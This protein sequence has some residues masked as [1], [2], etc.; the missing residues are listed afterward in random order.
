MKTAKLG[1]YSVDPPALDAFHA[2]DPESFVTLLAISDALVAISPEGDVIPSLA[3]G[4]E[5][6]SP[7]TLELELREGVRF[8]NGEAFDADSVVATF[9]AHH[10]PTPSACGGG[11]LAS[12]SDVKRLG[13]HRV[14][15]TTAFPDAM[16]LRRLF[17]FSIYPKGVLESEGRGAMLRHPIGTG[18]WRFVHWEKGREILLARND[19][20]W[21][22]ASSIERISIPIIRQ[23][24][25]VD[26]MAAGELDIILNIDSHDAVRAG[27]VEG[28]EVSSREAAL[29]Q[30]FLLAHEG[31]LADVNV[32]R[33]LNHAIKRSLI[34][35][36]SE[37]GY[38]SP[39]RS[40][41]TV[42]SIGHTDDVPH[43]RYS[44]Q[45]ARRMLA[46]AGYPDGFTLRGLVSET[47]T[48]VYFA[49]RE[50]LGR[51]G[52]TLEADI[53]PRSQWI[54]QVVGGN[55]SGAPYGGDFALSIVDN[56][57]L[58]SVFHQFI[59][60]FS[61]GLFS[62]VRDEEYD[63]HFLK[64]ATA[65]G[66]G[67][68]A[69]E[70]RQALE[71]YAVEQAMLL[72]TVKQ[73]V[74]AACREGGRIDM[75]RSGH[76]DSWF[77]WTVDVAGEAQQ[78]LQPLPAPDNQDMRALIDGTS[79][80]GTF[81]LPQD[82]RFEQPWADHLWRSLQTSEQRWRLTHEPML[83]E[84]VT[85]IE[86]RN[87]LASI[88]SSTQRVAII[89]YDLEDQRRFANAG[90]TRMFGE[91][92]RHIA[93][94]LDSPAWE[95]IVDGVDG[96]GS[97]L[98]PVT[99]KVE[100]MPEDT[101]SHLYLTATPSLDDEGAPTGITLVFSDFSG[102]EE[103]IRNQAVQ[104]ILDN[105]PYGLFVVGSDGA[106][107]S[108]FSEACA[109]L[110]P[111]VEALEGARLTDLLEM[112]ERDATGL[113][114]SIDQVFDDWMP[115]DVTLGQLPERVAVGERTL[116]MSASV[117]RDPHGAVDA[118]LFTVA[119]IS[120][121]IEAEREIER[122][123]STLKVLQFRDRFEGFVS[124]LAT[125]F[126]SLAA[127]AGADGW[128]DLARRV[129]HTAKGV[130]GQFGLSSLQRTIHEL[131]ESETIAVHHLDEARGAVEVEL[132]KRE[133]I[134]GIRFEG[135]QARYAISE[136][137]LEQLEAA[138]TGSSDMQQARSLAL[139][140]LEQVRCKPASSILGPLD[141]AVRQL[142]ERR[143]KSID[144]VFS[145]MESQLPVRLSSV[146]DQLGHLVRNAVDH[147]IETPEDRGDKPE[148]A[149]ITVSVHRAD[150]AWSVIVSDDGAGIDGERVARKAV[151]MGM[152]SEA[153][154]AAMSPQE[155]VALVFSDG[156]STAQTVSDSSGRGVGMAAV[157]AAVEAI[158]GVIRIESVPGVGTTTSLTLP[159]ANARSLREVA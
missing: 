134:W 45:L 13:E 9:K 105:V 129:L 33:A 128:Q 28:I 157:R 7:L 135:V 68:G 71:R 37:H 121:L 114:M 3:T 130:F 112:N 138:L 118:L 64:A 139:P 47:S 83:K 144:V 150:G 151:G 72:F 117:I 16:L 99:L 79:H 22:G 137:I 6:T 14:E 80:S 2:F 153:E 59:F 42:E 84:L 36:V 48:G 65:T 69:N 136:A 125:D 67:E 62:L 34:A 40:V 15:V 82:H 154:A 95:T 49:V 76:F 78:P 58:D 91:T 143:G 120:D 119:D 50:F 141:S 100:E 54:G 63:A 43:F 107:R 115:E 126:D 29:S 73:Q 60:L 31:P 25:W 98:G 35:E 89:G 5:R 87:H 77:W 24:E 127:T 116:S 103:R 124:E 52:V 155:K 104:V 93:E 96:E 1:I 39:Q 81:F 113:S 158:G 61:Q 122:M 27:R 97:W 70:A 10:D 92:E 74:H 156:L 85:Q 133:G 106:L 32:R 4:W 131:E 102:E 44:P 51:V 109:A 146:F 26:R 8:H 12:I 90:F 20:H 46:D 41:A 18:A 75:P 147:G 57:L 23:K 56:P 142:A 159:D 111:D 152:L 11:I 110:F 88:L 66:D 19:E 145:G 21:R 38:A 30:W 132:K 148:I 108:G 55:L 94:L 17:F 86:A 101:S 149:T 140:L 123:R 53:V